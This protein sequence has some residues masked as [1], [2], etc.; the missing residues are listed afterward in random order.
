M[1]PVYTTNLLDL[2]LATATAD[3][4]PLNSLTLND[5]M[6]SLAS[7]EEK[8]ECIKVI[9]KTFSDDPFERKPFRSV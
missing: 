7:E 3:S 9:L 1:S 6:R 8:L 5:L 4:L 2:I